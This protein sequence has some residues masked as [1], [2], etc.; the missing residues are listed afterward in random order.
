MVYF[1]EIPRPTENWKRKEINHCIYK[2]NLYVRTIGIK[3]SKK[4]IITEIKMALNYIEMPE[5]LLAYLL[6]FV[7]FKERTKLAVICRKFRSSVMSANKH[8]TNF[9]FVIELTEGH[10]FLIL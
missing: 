5:H 4:H 9:E 2:Y 7:N 8:D 3:R 1:N 10:I 6:S